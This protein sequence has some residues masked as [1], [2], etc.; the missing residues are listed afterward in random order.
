MNLSEL[1]ICLVVVLLFVMSIVLLS[2]KGAFLIAG[3]NTASKEEQSTYDRKK[4]CRVI[5]EG[6]WCSPSSWP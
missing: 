3:Y 2:G 4:L 6:S 5:G 1:I